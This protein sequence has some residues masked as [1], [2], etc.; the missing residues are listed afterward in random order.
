[1]RFTRVCWMA[2]LV[3]IAGYGRS[4]STMLDIL[5]GNHPD[6]FGAGEIHKIFDYMQFGMD[7][8][9]GRSL[10]NCEFWQAVLAR[11]P[12]CSREMALSQAHFITRS[13]EEWPFLAGQPGKRAENKALYRELWSSLLDAVYAESGAGTI[14]DSSKSGRRARRRISALKALGR[15]DITIL[16]LVRDPRAVMVSMLKGSNRKLEMGLPPGIPGGAYRVLVGWWFANR[17]VHQTA[18]MHPD[19]PYLRIRY[20]SLVKDP[21]DV[22]ARIGEKIGVDMDP[23]LDLLSS[24][25]PLDPGH[26]AAGNRLRRQ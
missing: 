9:C 14:V 19:L 17:S 1:M 4:G 13:Q 20:E 6:I 21:V 23:V 2:K 16:H 3:Y 18:R 11:T 15:Y 5:L 12:V 10:K 24:D 8:S 26:G 22:L 25:P 7:C